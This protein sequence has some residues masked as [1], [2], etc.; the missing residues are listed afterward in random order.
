LKRNLLVVLMVLVFAVSVHAED[1]TTV[2]AESSEI[3]ENLDLN[4]VASVFGEAENLE[5]FE[6]KLNDPDTQISNLDLNEDGEV[7]YLRVLETSKGD[8]HL[9]T[10]QAV[11]GKDKYQDVATVDVE[12]DSVQVVGDVAMYGPSY[13]V[14]PVYVHP[15]VIFV[16]FWGPLYHPWHSPYY[17]GYYPPYY[18]PWRPYPRAHYHRNVNVH[19]NVNNT[20]NVTSVRKSKTSVELSKKSR[21]SDAKLKRSDRQGVQRPVATTGKKVQADWTP[22]TERGA[23]LVESGKKK[24]TVPAKKGSQLVDEGRGQ[25]VEAVK[26]EIR[27][28]APVRETPAAPA[29]NL[30]ARPSG[31]VRSN[32]LGR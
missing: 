16:F 19:I 22:P 29:R 28:P 21:R 4:A 3:A 5:D 8:T 17:W 24:V 31:Q 11:I 25:G 27:A 2:E 1:V 6:K 14:E 30:P 7:D 12:K 9:V 20:Y 26:K 32:L 18:R 15:P 13:I 10:I 23:E